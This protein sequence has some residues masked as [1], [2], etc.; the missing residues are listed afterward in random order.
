[1]R[2]SIALLSSLLASALVPRHVRGQ[3]STLTLSPKPLPPFAAELLVGDGVTQRDIA[4]PRS[5]DSDLYIIRLYEVPEIGGCEGTDETCRRHYALL[6]GVGGMPPTFTIF[7]LG[8]V[9]EIEE[10]QWVSSPPRRRISDNPPVVGP[11]AEATLL[12]T[13]QNYPSSILQHHRD[14]I[15]QVR[16]YRVVTRLDTLI[17]TPSN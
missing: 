12:L 14:L 17:I 10:V 1:M 3:D 2:T 7:D 15:R 8:I 13:V 5:I 9:G 6:L 4:R 11:S 16:R